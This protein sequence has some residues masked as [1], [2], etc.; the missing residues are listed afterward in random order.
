MKWLAKVCLRTWVSCPFG[1][2]SPALETADRNRSMQAMKKRL[3]IAALPFQ[4]LP[5][6]CS[7]S[8]ASRPFEIGTE[9]FF[10]LFV[11]E[12]FSI[13]PRT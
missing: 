3:A 1:N 4:Y 12:K 8:S 7:H 10:P 5:L 2:A 11:P 13:P 6:R 9:R